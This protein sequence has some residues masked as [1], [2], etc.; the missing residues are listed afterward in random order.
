MKDGSTEYA[1]FI[2]FR[3]GMFAENP[4]ETEDRL[5][6]P[7]LPIPVSFFY[8]DVDWMDRKG[9]DRTV[10]RNKFANNLSSVYIINGSDHH[11]YLDNP[12][13][14]V[15]SLIHDILYT[16]DRYE[17]VTGQYGD[18][19]TANRMTERPVEKNIQ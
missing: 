2:C 4:L 12:E 7:N 14:F 11:M 9:G 13:E 3:L 15:Q 1:I 5:G 17:L 6:N 18:H 16:N 10:A 8:G 19:Y